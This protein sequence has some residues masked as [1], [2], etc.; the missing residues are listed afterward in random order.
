MFA[1]ID[2]VISVALITTAANLWVC[3]TFYDTS[4]ATRLY[5]SLSH[6]VTPSPKYKSIHAFQLQVLPSTELQ[7]ARLA[8]FSK[9]HKHFCLL[10]FHYVLLLRSV[11]GVL[12]SLLSAKV[13]SRRIIHMNELFDR[14]VKWSPP[15]SDAIRY[16]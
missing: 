5:M 15:L 12:F 9:W 11:S 6:S 10:C 2:A 8:R 13:Y 14:V 3:F 4:A 16:K 7:D 1:A